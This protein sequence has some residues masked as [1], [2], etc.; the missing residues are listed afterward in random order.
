MKRTLPSLRRLHF[1]GRPDGRTT[2][3]DSGSQ[4]SRPV[5]GAATYLD[6]LSAHKTFDGLPYLRSPKQPQ[7]PTQTTLRAPPDGL[8]EGADRHFHAGISVRDLVVGDGMVD[9]SVLEG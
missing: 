2:I 1:R 3:T 9:G 5:A 6:G 4:P 8:A 7:H